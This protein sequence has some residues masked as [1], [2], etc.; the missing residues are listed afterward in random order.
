M[1][2]CEE[3]KASLDADYQATDLLYGEKATAYVHLVAQCLSKKQEYCAGMPPGQCCQ[4]MSQL[5]YNTA[6][7]S[8]SWA[9]LYH[10]YQQQYGDARA[11]VDC[12]S[13]NWSQYVSAARSKLDQMNAMILQME[14]M[15]F[16]HVQSKN[17][18]IDQCG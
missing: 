15:Y 17:A 8:N 16:T 13:L 14:D 18:I 5:Y 10:Q 6:Q 12:E 9:S 4:Q 2:T 1:P 7:A 11:A 3:A